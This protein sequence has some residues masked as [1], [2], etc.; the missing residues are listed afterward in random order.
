MNFHYL[1]LP[2]CKYPVFS[3]NSEWL[4]DD[5]VADLKK[6]VRDVF[7]DFYAHAAILMQDSLVQIPNLLPY[8]YF[9]QSNQRNTAIL[10]F[11]SFTSS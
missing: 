8:L 9:D 4:R 1:P 6:N 3:E 5:E 11:T 7:S 10:F 2:L